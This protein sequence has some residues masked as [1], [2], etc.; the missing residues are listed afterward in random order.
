MV[1]LLMAIEAQPQ[2]IKVEKPQYAAVWDV[3]TQCPAQVFYILTPD[4]LG[5]AK[6]KPF[7]RFKRDISHPFMMASHGDYTKSGFHRGHLLPA[8][9]R[10]S[11]AQEMKETFCMSNVAPQTPSLNCGEWKQTENYVRRLT[12]YYDS[13][14]VLVVP[15][16][17]ARDTVR[18]SSAQVC[19]PHAFFKAVWN[20][21]NDSVLCAWFV[22]NK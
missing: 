22:F 3:A 7:W 1:L 12:A 4:N 17:L 5:S 6:R 9:D 18:F 10:S 15:I 8:Q 19:V 11:S 20:L 14:G 2:K 13:I 21:K 16:Y